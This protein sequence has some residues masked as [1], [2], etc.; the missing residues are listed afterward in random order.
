MPVCAF[1]VFVFNVEQSGKQIPTVLF[2]KNLIF[3]L[4]FALGAN[5]RV[6][7]SNEIL[8]LSSRL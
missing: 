6:E 8:L 3:V 4:L 5:L 7:N 2:K 1:Y